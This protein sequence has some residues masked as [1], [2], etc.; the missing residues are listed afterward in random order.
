MRDNNAMAYETWRDLLKAMLKTPGQR[1]KLADEL[2]INAVTINRWIS[3]ESK[4]RHHNLRS[5]LHALR[6]DEHHDE[7]RR[8]L[9]LEF[10]DLG[11]EEQRKAER[12]RIDIPS[13]LYEKLIEL[14]VYYRDDRRTFEVIQRFLRPALDLLDPHHTGITLRIVRCT[15][16]RD[17]MAGFVRSSWTLGGVG[18]APFPRLLPLDPIYMGLDTIAG[19]TIA[20]A[21]PQVVHDRE[22]L[23][24]RIPVQW[25]PLEESA[26]AAPIIREGRAIAGCL[27]ATSATKWFFTDERLYLLRNLAHLISLAFL[28]T[29]FFEFS[30]VRLLCMPPY[31]LQKVILDTLAMRVTQKN[32]AADLTPP[33]SR[34]TYVQVWN[35]VWQDMEDQLLLLPKEYHDTW[36]PTHRP[37]LERGRAKMR[38]I[39]RKINEE[40]LEYLKVN[41]GL[42]KHAIED[43]PYIRE[44]L[45][46]YN[47]EMFQMLV[48]A[49]LMTP[50]GN[51]AFD[52]KEGEEHYYPYKV[53]ESE[54]P[55]G[56]P[57]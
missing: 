15:C 33:D 35:E 14:M 56:P 25:F 24:N 54:A 12:P 5:L 49:G 21:Q 27:L 29:D 36:D 9:I 28:P 37:D 39:R 26:A 23:S 4:P 46:K 32:H 45:M 57:E 7:M 16:P 43:V 48:N 6:G 18:S 20:R 42:L 47:P 10:G 40:Q 31:A 13:R 2:Q 34:L 8:L 17:R 53:L 3:G 41:R 52:L 44:R 50:E 30:R 38:E 22:D 19:A 1:Q 55:W 11:P 51:I